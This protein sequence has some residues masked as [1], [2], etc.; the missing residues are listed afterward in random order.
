VAHQ[1]AL[2]ELAGPKI[3]AE[4][5]AFG[6]WPATDHFVDFPHERLEIRRSH[7]QNIYFL[8]E[9]AGRSLAMNRVC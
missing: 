2:L 5:V 7:A 8:L 1:H 3:G 6:G 4:F 9:E